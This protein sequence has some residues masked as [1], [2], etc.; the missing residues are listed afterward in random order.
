MIFLPF[1]LF[2]GLTDAILGYFYADKALFRIVGLKKTGNLRV[3]NVQIFKHLYC[4][5]SLQKIVLLQDF[6][7]FV[8]H[9]Y[10]L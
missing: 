6:R 3:I 9:P 2:S 1:K 8:Y 4:E 5:F 10:G 7:P